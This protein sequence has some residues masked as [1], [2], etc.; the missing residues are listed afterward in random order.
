MS[1][2][3]GGRNSIMSNPIYNFDGKPPPPLLHPVLP[4]DMNSSAFLVDLYALQRKKLLQRKS[5]RTSRRTPSR[6]HLLSENHRHPSAPKKAPQEHNYCF[7]ITSF[8][9]C[10]AGCVLQIWSLS[11]TAAGGYFAYDVVTTVTVAYKHSLE[12]PMRTYCFYTTDIIRWDEI[13]KN[14]NIMAKAAEISGQ[15][16]SYYGF[17]YTNVSPEEFANSSRAADSHQEKLQLDALVKK[18]LTARSLLNVTFNF[19][20]IFHICSYIKKSNYTVK[21]ESCGEVYQTRKFLFKSYTCFEMFP[22]KH[23]EYELSSVQ[24]VY[25]YNPGMVSSISVSK[26]FYS[27]VKQGLLYVHDPKE[28]PSSQNSRSIV[29]S[30]MGRLFSVSYVEYE[31]TFL[32]SPYPSN[33]RNYTEE[34]FGTQVNCI[35][36]CTANATRQKLGYNSLLVPVIRKTK[37]DSI[38]DSYLDMKVMSD[39]ALLE[40]ITL[41]NASRL[42]SKTCNRKCYQLDCDDINIGPVLLSVNAYPFSFFTFHLSYE[43]DVKTATIE[44]VGITSYLSDIASALGFWLGISFLSTLDYTTKILSQIIK[45]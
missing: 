5:I 2:S 35:N 14:S 33:C 37:G 10:L 6:I 12:Y 1:D 9:V 25:A 15:T 42:I 16:P 34:G 20:D 41:F 39:N 38:D 21:A 3:R 36:S 45:K 24:L 31:S 11:A 22:K 44:K 19:N 18:Y 26:T 28:L 8:L 30:E 23:R 4:S 32:P 17:G 27:K 40:N 13:L 7:Q 43:P 29:L